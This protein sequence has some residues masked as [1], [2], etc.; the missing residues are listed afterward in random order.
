[1]GLLEKSKKLFEFVPYDILPL[2]S[3]RDKLKEAKINFVDIEFPPVEAS[4]Y[5]PGEML[6][7][8]ANENIVWKR[9][10]DFMIVDEK[11]GLFEPE[12]FNKSIEPNDI[13]QGMLGDCWF[14]CALASLA[15]M[16]KLVE[17]LFV[18]KKFNED[19]LYRVKLCKNGAWTEVT[20]DDYFPCTE[21]GGP[22]FSRANGNELWVLLLEKAYAKL[23][24]NYYALRAGF[25][26]EG[27]A[28]LTG[29]PTECYE[30]EDS[31]TAALIETGEL[32]KKM[33]EFDDAGYLISASTAGEDK[34]TEDREAEKPD[35]GGLIPGHAYS[36]I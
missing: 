35:D 20:I 18:T 14:M 32:F 3:I 12:V 36:I 4:I 34:F 22:I 31:E 24:G 2:D 28:D 6:K 5:N 9:P 26:N 17:R 19:G 13:K 7:P 29:S 30:F 15:E 33:K 11:R 8:F 1:M 25:A 16:P 10:K 21:R 23:H 27:M